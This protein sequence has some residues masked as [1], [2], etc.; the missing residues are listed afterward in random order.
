MKLLSII[1]PVFNVEA[2]LQR[3]LDSLIVQDVDKEL[4]EVVIINDGSTDNSLTIA[5]NCKK[6]NTNVIVINQE[7]TGLGGARNT[8]LKYASGEYI[9]FVDSDDYLQLNSLKSIID[10]IRISNVEL[11]RLNYNLRD[12]NGNIIP[13]KKNA[14]YNVHYSDNKVDGITFITDFLGWSCYAWL[15]L[16]KR[17]FIINNHFV[18]H[19]N[20]YYEDV[21]WLL[22]VLQRAKKVCSFDYTIYNYV[23]RKGSI[24]KSTLH[25]KKLK[26]FCDKLSVVDFI[27]VYS[28]EI[29]NQKLKQWCSG[30]ISLQIM[31]MLRFA[32]CELPEKKTDLLDYIHS[33]QL[34][35]FKG[36]QFT[37]KQNRDLFLMNLSPGLYMYLRK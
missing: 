34:R 33:K 26:T 14:L 4:Y 20:I 21:I 37:L 3:C 12:E 13:K 22:Q 30:F 35:P 8:G 11:L 28:R 31:G 36:Y 23:Q 7:N 18:F 6:E 32:I 17:D 1:V 19:E 10:F 15:Y 16:Y 29:G 9:L 5:L 24:T 27:S 2:Y 25:S